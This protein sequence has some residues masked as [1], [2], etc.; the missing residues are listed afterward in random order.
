PGESSVETSVREHK[1]NALQC[2]D[3]ES[4]IREIRSSGLMRS[5]VEVRNQQLRSVQPATF[6][7]AYSTNRLLTQIF[8]CQPRPALQNRRMRYFVSLVFGGVLLAMPALARPSN[9]IINA[10]QV[11]EVNGR[12]V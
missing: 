11:L 3:P 1:P 7:F 5:E 2:S 12:K 10:D 8:G 4:R 9:V 6:H